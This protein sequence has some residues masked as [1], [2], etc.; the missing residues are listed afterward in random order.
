MLSAGLALVG[1]CGHASS[2]G[3]ARSD[4]PQEPREVQL[5]SVQTMSFVRTVRSTG[6]LFGD[7]QTTIAAKVSGRVQ[8]VHVD[9]GDD[10][11]PG[12]PLITI[13]ATDY[14]LARDERRMAFEQ[15]LARLGLSALP[16]GE[17]DLTALPTVQRA[18]LEAE[19]AR[20]RYER[21]KQLA[22]REPPLISEQDFADLQTAWEVARS[23]LR[24]EELEAQAGVAESRTLEA[25]LKIAEQ[26]V[27][28]TVHRAPKEAGADSRVF[29]VSRRMVAVGDFVQVGDPIMHLIDLNPVKLRASVTE[30]MIGAVKPGQLVSVRTESLNEAVRG[31]VTRVSPAVDERTRTS[32]VEI[33][34]DN[35]DRLLKPGSFATAEI[36]IGTDSALAVPRDCISTFA[37]LS[38]VFVVR[39]G[40]AESVR[41]ETG[42]I[43]GDWIELRSGLTGEERVIRAPAAD[44][45]AG[46]PVRETQIEQASGSEP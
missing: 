39:D 11:H 22:E 21:G 24:V 44:L 28:D 12:D 8:T 20:H 26:R 40:I 17:L 9:L 2:A 41:V 25:Q 30:R 23:N 13:E 1:G 29:A 18:A 46:T 31:V 43:V 38:K 34:I 5:T 10:A 19:N 37:G 45:V 14:V 4:A 33:T 16:D 36:E 35:P 32:I 7:E 42:S 6:T 15:S 27:T 3:S